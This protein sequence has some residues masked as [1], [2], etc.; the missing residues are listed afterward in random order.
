MTGVQEPGPL[1][2][3]EAMEETV[4]EAEA[5]GQW[6]TP[7]TGD[8]THSRARRRNTTAF[9][10][11]SPSDLLDLAIPLLGIYSGEK[12]VCVHGESCRDMFFITFFEIE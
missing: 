3:A 1:G 6:R 8:S 2:E 9:S 11:F 5:E 7:I 4:V 10:F 12:C